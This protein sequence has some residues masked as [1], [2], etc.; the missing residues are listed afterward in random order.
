MMEPTYTRG[1][2]ISTHPAEAQVAP[3]A[4]TGWPSFDT[5]AA[6]KVAGRPLRGVRMRRAIGLVVWWMAA[7]QR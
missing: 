5:G 1:A 6:R 4:E 7:A 3:M 2:L